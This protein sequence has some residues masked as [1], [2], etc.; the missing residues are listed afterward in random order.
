MFGRGNENLTWISTFQVDISK[1]PIDN[2]FQLHYVN[3]Y[4]AYPDNKEI[5]NKIPLHL[6]FLCGDR[7]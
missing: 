7:P 6:P 2:K 5:S 4:G 3:R 1:T